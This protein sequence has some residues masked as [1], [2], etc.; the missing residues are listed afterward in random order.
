MSKGNKL[1]QTGRTKSGRAQ[2]AEEVSEFVIENDM[3]QVFGGDI[4]RDYTH[5]SKP[6]VISYSRRAVLDGSV[7]IYGPTFIRVQEGGPAAKVPES[8]A[9][10]KTEA[11]FWKHMNQHKR[12]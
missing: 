5:K 1:H 10:F 9:V 12:S 3:C 2:L 11:D 6:Y 4:S 8:G 7:T